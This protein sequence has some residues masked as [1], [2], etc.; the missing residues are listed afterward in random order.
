MRV[1]KK[2]ELNGGEWKK[3]WHSVVEYDHFYGKAK[4]QCDEC[5]G[6]F[7]AHSQERRPKKDSSIA[8]HV[9]SPKERNYND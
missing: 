9:Q 7:V 4:F 5:L 6:T 3:T 1:R 8:G 2:N